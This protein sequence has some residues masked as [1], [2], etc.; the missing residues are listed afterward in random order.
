VYE[1]RQEVAKGWCF[2]LA[3][4]IEKGLFPKECP[5]VADMT[6]YVGAKVL[7]DDQYAQMKP[8]IKS[9][10]ASNPIPKWA[11]WE[12]F[13]TFVHGQDRID[14]LKKSGNFDP[15]MQRWYEENEPEGFE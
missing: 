1:D 13:A 15:D 11:N 5:Y 10:V 12:Q 2:P 14:S 3:E 4:A 9:T 7:T 6:E 8:L